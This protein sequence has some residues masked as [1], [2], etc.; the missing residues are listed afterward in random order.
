[1]DLSGKEF[2]QKR[3]IDLADVQPTKDAYVLND[4]GPAGGW[5]AVTQSMTLDKPLELEEDVNLILCDGVTLQC[6]DGVV[7]T[8][9]AGRLDRGNAGEI[10]LQG[11]G[12]V[13]NGSLEKSF[14][15]HR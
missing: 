7:V 5:Y 15:A 1:M 13:G 9:H 2:T 6:N 4:N 3:Y 14:T 12:N 10:S 8:G 11:V